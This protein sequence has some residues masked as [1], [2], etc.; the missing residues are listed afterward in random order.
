MLTDTCIYTIKH[1]DDLETAAEA[2]EPVTFTEDK[3]W[4]TA[5]KMLIGALRLGERVPIIFAPAEFTRFLFGWALLDKVVL[6][7]DTT[8]YTFSQFQK[9]KKEAHRKTTL[10]K[11]SNAEPLHADFIRPYAICLTPAYFKNKSE[12]EGLV[13]GK[14][15]EQK[16]SRRRRGK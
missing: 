6:K 7:N 4:V 13:G 5:Q 2:R 12:K 16:S 11:A 8:E 9:F 14:K 15:L 10:R 1:T 3:R